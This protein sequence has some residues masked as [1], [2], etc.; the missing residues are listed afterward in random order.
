MPANC[1]VRLQHL[2][3]SVNKAVKTFLR[4]E[5]QDWYANE[6]SKEYTNSESHDSNTGISPIDLSTS[7]MKCLGGQWLGKMFDYL[8]NNS[9]IIC[10]GF[11][12]AHIPHSID[13]GVPVLEDEVPIS[14]HENSE[15]DEENEEISDD[16]AEEGSEEISV[17]ISKKEENEID[18][19]LIN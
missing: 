3:I 8:S 17:E 2:D 6:V 10:N 12:A 4:S 14:E 11:H 1:T 18:T 19:I 16:N 9:S 15:D 7:R 5:F 13:A